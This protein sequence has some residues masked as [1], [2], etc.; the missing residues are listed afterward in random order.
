SFSL[1]LFR[2]IL[3]DSGYIKIDDVDI[4]TIRLHDLRSRISIIPQ[5]PVLFSGTVRSNLD[6]F[7]EYTDEQLNESLRRVHL[8]PQTI[9]PS[10]TTSGTATP[11]SVVTVKQNPFT[12]LSSP[13]SEGG[14]NLSQGQRQLLCLARSC[15]LKPKILLLDEATSSI[16][17]ETEEAIRESLNNSF[18]ET[19]T[20]IIAH[21]LEGV[22][23]ADRVVVMG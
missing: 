22:M 23:D 20:I 2:F 19:T 5:D 17:L 7:D 3:A 4:S 18:G 15:V 10:A 6:P 1:A 21:R 14:L 8:I 12:D 16:D 13:I 9:A 11:A